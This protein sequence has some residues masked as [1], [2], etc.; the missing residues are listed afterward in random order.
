MIGSCETGLK[1]DIRAKKW[2]LM[3]ARTARF[4]A[5]EDIAH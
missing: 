5:G 4:A 3:D 1:R 2:D